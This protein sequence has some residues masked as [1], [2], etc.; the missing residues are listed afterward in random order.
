MKTAPQD[1]AEP[2]ENIDYQEVGRFGGRF[3]VVL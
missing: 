3:S 1:L 2:F